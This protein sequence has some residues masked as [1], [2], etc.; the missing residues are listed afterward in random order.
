MTSIRTYQVTVSFHLER[1]CIS[2]AGQR[3]WDSFAKLHYMRVL[4]HPASAYMLSLQCRKL[5]DSVYITRRKRD[6]FGG[7]SEDLRQVF[8]FFVSY[9]H[10]LVFYIYKRLWESEE[11]VCKDVLQYSPQ[12]KHMLPLWYSPWVTSFL[13]LIRHLLSIVSLYIVFFFFLYHPC[14]KP[15]GIRQLSSSV[16]HPWF[17]WRYMNFFVLFLFRLYA[18]YRNIV[19]T[20]HY[21]PF[22]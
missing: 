6:L 5:L 11:H 17:A 1:N 19:I 21:L 12:Y 13:Y 7:I 20:C 2:S 10:C 18:T 3:R 16:V 4:Q 8:I 14:P 22:A 9:T 15:S